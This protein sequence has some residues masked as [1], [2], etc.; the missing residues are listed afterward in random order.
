MSFLIYLISF[1]EWFTTLSVEI[2]AIRRFTPIIWTNSIST[3]IILWVILLALSYGY[4][5]GWKNTKNLESKDLIK[6]IIFNLTVAWTYYL[7]FTFIFDQLILSYLI[8]Y[9]QSYF[10]AILLS[11]FLLFFIPVFL[12]SQTIPLLSEVLKWENTWEK[13][14]K[15]LFFSTV[16]SFLGSVMT[17][18]VLFPFIWVYK[19]S[20][21]DS[22]L[23]TFSSVILIWY[24]FKKYKEINFVSILSI[25][26]F[27]LSIILIIKPDSLSK[28]SLFKIANSYHDIEIYD[29]NE[30]TRIFSMNWWYS[31]GID[32]TTKESFFNYIKEI[33]KNISE[34][35]GKNLKILIIGW[36]GFTLPKELSEKENIDLIDVVDVDPNLKDISEK[37]F[38]QE[39]LSKKVNF[40]VEPSRYFLN[41]AIKNNKFY[42]EIVID[43]YVGK[44]LPSQ[45]LTEEFFKNIKKIGKNINTNIISDLELK[46]DF[47]KNLFNT[48]QKTFWKLYFKSELDENREWNYLTNIVVSNNYFPDY[49]QYN[50]DK[51]FWIY[52]DNKNSIEIDVFKR[53]L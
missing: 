33:K 23:L 41:N 3:S 1:L 22:F 38:L 7:F 15:L 12:A 5:I 20:I 31:S 10:F 48:M 47:S 30:N 18:S 9:I 27:F 49:S 34:N 39:K 43:I 32:K 36:A 26:I 11:S 6:K 17:S 21:F 28:N 29:T 52:T 46:T 16:G 50:F 35:K 13:V 14:W 53:G 19:S 42:D 44:S 25:I 37:Y 24:I 40:I 51:N 45:T 2:I 8:L 4:Y